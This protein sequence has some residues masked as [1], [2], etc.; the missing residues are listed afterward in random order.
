[1]HF[2][3][4]NLKANYIKLNIILII[5]R[6]LANQINSGTSSIFS[7]RNFGEAANVLNKIFLKREQVS[8][9][10]VVAR[11]MSDRLS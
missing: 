10:N 4:K 5:P 9:V 11:K 1:M 8:T 2:Y 7:L 3:R 6:L